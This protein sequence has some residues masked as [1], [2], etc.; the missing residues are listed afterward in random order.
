[1]CALVVKLVKAEQDRRLI[2]FLMWL[3]EMYIVF[4][5]NILMMNILPSTAQA[6]AKLTQEEKQRE[7][8]PHNHSALDSTSL[9]VS[10]STYN[11]ACTKRGVIIHLE[12]MQEQVEI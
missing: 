5:G 7:V 12:K 9:N 3:N 2:H 6:F 11:T 4:R 8:K 1:M 10:S